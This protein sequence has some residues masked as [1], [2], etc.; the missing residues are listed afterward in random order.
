MNGIYKETNVKNNQ[1]DQNK[2]IAAVAVGFGVMYVVERVKRYRLELHNQR[3]ALLMKAR[4]Q[5]LVKYV[6]SDGDDGDAESNLAVDRK[7]IEIV[8]KNNLD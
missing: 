2:A 5:A 3:H 7:F 4:V 6:Y 1:N 8:E